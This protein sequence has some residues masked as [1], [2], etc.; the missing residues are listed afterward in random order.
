MDKRK[1]CQEEIA[2][3]WPGSKQ[4]IGGITYDTEDP[5]TR[6]IG[7]GP[8]AARYI[9]EQKSPYPARR[10]YYRRDGKYFMHIHTADG[11]IEPLHAADARHYMDHDGFDQCINEEEKEEVKQGDGLNKQ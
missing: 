2:R 6:L 9:T 10:L 5:E 7:Y 11:K 8:E 3:K 1:D 4:V